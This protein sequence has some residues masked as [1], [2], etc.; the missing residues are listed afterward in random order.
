MPSRPDLSV[1]FPVFNAADNLPELERRL[2]PALRGLGAYELVAVDDGSRDGSLRLLKAWARRSRGR[3]R[4]LALPR[5]GG[6]HAALLR[7]LA[8]CRGRVVV[9]MDDDLQHPPEAIGRL[10]QALTAGVDV[11]YGVGTSPSQAWWRELLSPLARRLLSLSIPGLCPRFS[12]FRA[13]RREAV[14]RALPGAAEH[15]FVDG[16]L[17]ASGARARW[18]P[19]ALAVRTRGSSSYSLAGLAAYAWGAFRAYSPL[20]RRLAPPRRSAS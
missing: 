18:V 7:G 3:L 2:K 6:Q 5:N 20:G 11:V 10:M 19:V 8:L 9:T 15:P 4:V 17:A 13:L 1:L 12:A 16:A 14:L